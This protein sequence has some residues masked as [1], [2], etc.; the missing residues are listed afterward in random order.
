MIRGLT[1]AVGVLAA[2]YG[3]YWFVAADTAGKAAETLVERLRAQGLTVEYSDLATRGFPSRIDTTVT[4]LAVSDPDSGLGWQA[5]WFQV[6]AL[7]YRPNQ[8][9]A[10]WPEVQTLTLAD[11]VLTVASQD[12]RASAHVGLSTDLPLAQATVEATPLTVTATEAGWTA[13]AAHVIAAFRK[14]EAG[15]ADYDL[16]AELD[17]LALPAPVLALIDPDGSLPGA[18]DI[19]RLDATV[20]FD[21]PI[22]AAGGQPVLQAVT[23]REARITWGGI[24]V[25]V[26][27]Q[28]ATGESGRAEGELVADITDWSRLLDLAVAAGA[29][30]QDQA[31]M[32]RNAMSLAAAGDENLSA[33][34]H[35]RNGLVF[36]GPVPIGV[37]PVLPLSAAPAAP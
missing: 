23:I 4:D 32:W 6:F 19:A 5:P 33:P 18:V 12:M 21:Q 22:D 30:S 2:G 35:L 29:L 8:I 9:I 15:A 27:G 3:G 24:A 17:S 34:L 14:A 25:S 31:P 36:L 37:A 13:G 20:T 11:E 7:S 10:A 26:T 28:L 16:F 1:I